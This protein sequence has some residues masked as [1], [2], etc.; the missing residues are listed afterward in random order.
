MDEG[1]AVDLMARYGA[2]KTDEELRAVTR[3]LEQ[4][5]VERGLQKVEGELDAVT[6]ALIS[7][8]P[9][10]RR[11]GPRGVGPGRRRA[12]GQ[13]PPARTSEY[14]PR[15]AGDDY[16]RLGQVASVQTNGDRL[17][18]GWLMFGRFAAG[19]PYLAAYLEER[20]CDDLKVGI[21]DFDDVRG[22]LSDPGRQPRLWY[23]PRRGGTHLRR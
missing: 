8:T 19:M 5:L 7:Q 14:G 22:R 21:V 12:N 17:E 4:R 15:P 13:R 11:R 2:A 6:L 3:E 16:A 1:W 20:G 9:D 10:R 18:L 23:R